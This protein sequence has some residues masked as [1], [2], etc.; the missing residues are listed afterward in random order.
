MHGLPPTDRDR[1]KFDWSKTA[2]DYARHRPGY[3]PEFYT[4]LA[5]LGVGLPGQRIVDLGTGTGA[6][7]RALAQRGAEVIGV[8]VAEA[9]I[10]RARELAEAE[11]LSARFEI[12]PAESTGLAAASF[13]FAVASQCWIYFDRDAV[14][15]E[16]DRLLVPGGKLVTCH[17]SWLVSHS[18]IV[19]ESEALV[20]RHNSGWRASGWRG[21]V[22][23]V[24]EWS[25]ERLRVVGQF[26]FDVDIPFTRESW[27]GRMRAC[28][29]VGATLD[30][31][32]IRAFDRDLDA[33][34]RQLAGESFVVPHRID[35]HVFAPKD[36]TFSAP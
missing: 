14:F 22:P 27:R 26:V 11:R 29:G 28:R 7:A 2:D 4:R 12:A 16:L 30:D 31:A 36:G 20:L 21:E 5:E 25:R 10:A 8:D 34:L 19:R 1:R 6:V 3:P 35:A 9:S 13:E 18:E 32:G 24:P 15:R 33:R 23:D 17:L